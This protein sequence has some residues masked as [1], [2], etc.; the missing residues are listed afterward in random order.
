MYLSKEQENT[1]IWS[2]LSEPGDALA[3]LIFLFRGAEAVS[4]IRTGRAKKLWSKVLEDSAPEYLAGLPAML[5]RVSLRLP[6][7]HVGI[8]VE[9]AVRWNARPVF[10]EDHK[11]LW[12]KFA[13]LELH[14]PYLLW[15]AGE[16]SVLD[17]SVVSVVGTREASAKGLQ[18]ARKLVKQIGFPVVSG[19]AKGIDAAAHQAALDL[20]LPTVA[21]MA[22]GI[23]RAYPQENWEL[24][25]KMVR[26]SGAL[27]SELVPFTAPSRFRFLQRN[28]LIAAA[29]NST[30]VVE[31][32]Y[33]SGSKN[34]ATH[35]RACGREVFAIPGSF[36]DTSAQGCNAMIK[37]GLA[38]PWML[39][40]RVQVEESMDAKRV[41]DAY[42]DGAR[43]PSEISA[44]SGIRITDIQRLLSELNSLG[45][46]IPAVTKL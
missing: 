12:G 45:D 40:A 26:S 20:G 37:E 10:P 43:T 30:F 36:S 25:H 35:A 24:F 39:N 34:T 21:F 3:Y 2:A 22:G 29:G 46:F 33:R 32:G 9:R 19:G 31:A 27:V 13:D 23:D 5:E 4:D 11:S 8:L 6:K 16:V 28:R 7:V 38:K 41:L 15:A 1:I 18:N 14:Q 44:E 42:R 17:Q